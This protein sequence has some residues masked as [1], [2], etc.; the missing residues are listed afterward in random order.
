M[1][2][3]ENTS[4]RFGEGST[5]VI[6]GVRHFKHVFN[7]DAARDAHVFGVRAVVEKQIVAE[8]FL[9]AAAMVAAKAR[10]GIR[11]H[12]A[13]AEAPAGIDAFADGHDVAD[14]FMAKDGRRLDH[15]GMVAAFPDFEVGA[16][17]ESEADTKKNFVGG[18]RRHVDFFDAKVFA[19]IEDRRHHFGWQRNACTSSFHFFAY[20][21]FFRSRPH[22]CVIKIF[23]DSAVGLAAN[24]KAS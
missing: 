23:N 19:A 12:Y 4:E 13:H 8:I 17:R 2:A 21:H 10:G 6:D 3:A 14:Q 18:Q 24:S 22:A 20:F 5:L 7:D 15:A 9:A 1:D 16:V 11:G